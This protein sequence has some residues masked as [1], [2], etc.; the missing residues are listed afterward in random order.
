MLAI[1]GPIEWMC[2]IHTFSLLFCSVHSLSLLNVSTW[3]FN[4]GNVLFYSLPSTFMHIHTENVLAWLGLAW[5]PD[6][7]LYREWKHWNGPSARFVRMRKRERARERKSERDRENDWMSQLGWKK[8]RNENERVQR[9]AHPYFSFEAKLN[10][11]QNTTIKIVCTRRPQLKIQRFS[12]SDTNCCYCCFC[13][14]SHSA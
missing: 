6:S 9:A 13:F 7:I 14:S 5:L 11:L 4:V 2:V 1:H 12:A 10:S 3:V 8:N